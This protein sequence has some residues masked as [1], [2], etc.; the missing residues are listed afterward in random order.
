MTFE[1]Q[2]N[3]INFRIARGA[4][5]LGSNTGE[6][7]AAAGLWA[8]LVLRGDEAKARDCDTF[9]VG[10]PRTRT[11][12]QGAC[13]RFWCKCVPWQ[14]REAAALRASSRTALAG[15]AGALA[16]PRRLQ[17]A[18]WSPVDEDSLFRQ[19]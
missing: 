18:D 9:S 15:K 16:E 11:L 17:A 6:R 19:L 7:G 4:Y 13:Q 14:E 5:C 10:S 12:C 1:V 8:W 3:F 2:T